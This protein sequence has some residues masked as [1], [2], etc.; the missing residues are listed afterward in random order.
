MSLPILDVYIYRGLRRGFYGKLLY[1]SWL[2]LRVG[3]E[4]L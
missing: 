4:S 2:M 3:G 1:G